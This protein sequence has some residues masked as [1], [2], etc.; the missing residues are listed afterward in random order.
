LCHIVNHRHIQVARIIQS[1]IKH[2]DLYSE[3]LVV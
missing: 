2:R 3:K 1:W